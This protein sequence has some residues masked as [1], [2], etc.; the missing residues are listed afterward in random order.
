MEDFMQAMVKLNTEGANGFQTFEQQARNSTSGIATSITVAKTQIVIGIAD[1]INSFDQLL[2]DNGL[3]GIGE[4]VSNIGKKSK[5]VLDLIANNLPGILSSVKELI[6]YI[7]SASI[8]WASW[9]V[10]TTVQNII[11]GF[12]KAKLT[13]ALY[14]MET[15]RSKYCTRTI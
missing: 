15:G 4:I 5:E 12:Q 8:I 14:T 3:G 10:G 6:P 11:T 7:K 9:K 13:L 2:K 1:I